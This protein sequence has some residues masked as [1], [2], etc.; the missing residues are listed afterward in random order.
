[1][2]EWTY[3]YTQINHSKLITTFLFQTRSVLN[4]TPAGMPNQSPRRLSLANL[5]INACTVFQAETVGRLV[6][7]KTLT[8]KG[9]L[10]TVLVQALAFRKDCKDD[11]KC[12]SVSQRKVCFFSRI[13]VT[14]K[15]RDG[16]V[17]A[18]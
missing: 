14:K 18:W 8:I 15:D 2:E 7:C 3:F 17:A 16:I 10:E 5:N 1:V 9:E 13:C 4:T 12:T 11:A 6:S